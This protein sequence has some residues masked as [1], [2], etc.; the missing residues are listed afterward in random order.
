MQI[1]I[2]PRREGKT[3]ELVKNV[4]KSILDGN[5]AIIV[6]TTEQHLNDLRKRY[7]KNKLF[8]K[9]NIKFVTCSDIENRFRGYSSKWIGFWD[10]IDYMHSVL[11]RKYDFYTCS[12]ISDL[13]DGTEK[14]FILDLLFVRVNDLD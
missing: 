4:Y 3:T 12:S 7:F 9:K 11:W 10:D 6:G 1:I 8:N 5:N 2:K 14:K 13:P